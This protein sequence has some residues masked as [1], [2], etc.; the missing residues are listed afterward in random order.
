MAALRGESVWRVPVGADG[1]AG[2]PTRH[3]QGTYGRIRDIRFVG[4]R[5]WVTTSNNTG[6]DRLISLPLSALGVG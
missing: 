1:T 4:G 6:T 3:V 5:A 2:T